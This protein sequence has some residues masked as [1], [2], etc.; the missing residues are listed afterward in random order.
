MNTKI[1]N[2]KLWNID[3]NGEPKKIEYSISQKF[4]ETI[5]TNFQYGEV[6]KTYEI[7]RGRYEI[8]NYISEKTDLKPGEININKQD[9]N[10]HP[11]QGA[12]FKIYGLK[13]NGGNNSPDNFEIEGTSDSSGSIKFTNI[14]PGV[15][16][17][18]ET[19]APEGYGQN[20]RT[21]TIT[22]RDDGSVEWT[23]NLISSAVSG[24]P[25][26]GTSWKS[27]VKYTNGSFSWP[28]YMNTLNYTEVDE[29]NNFTSY[30]M[31]KPDKNTLNDNG[32]KYSFTD[33]D[34]RIS[35]FG[36]SVNID[37]A[38]IFNV[39]PGQRQSVVDS[40]F[41][42]NAENLDLGNDLSG[43]KNTHD[44][45]IQR[46]KS[47][48]DN[49]LNKTV[50]FAFLIPFG[51]FGAPDPD[52]AY[53]FLIKVKGKVLSTNNADATISY[54][55]LTTSQPKKRPAHNYN[56]NIGDAEIGSQTKIENDTLIP[57]LNKRN[58]A[59]APTFTVVNTQ[60]K[61]TTLNIQ[62]LDDK[63]NQ[64][65]GAEF[66]LYNS[67]GQ[68]IRTGTTEVGGKLTFDKLAPGKY[69]LKETKSPSGYYNPELTFNV[70]VNPDGS[71]IYD[72][73]DKN[74]KQVEEGDLYKVGENKTGGTS[75][76]QGTKRITV[77]GEP[78]MYLNESNHY[79]KRPGVWEEA[80]YESY[81]FEAQFK[82]ENCKAGDSWV[83]DFD[84]NWNFTQ[85][86][87]EL[88]VLKVNDQEVARG[89]IDYRN[90][91]IKYTLTNPDYVDH[92][93]SIQVK[94]ELNS[95]R[96]SK[97]YVKN[98]GI[99][100]FR[101]I[102]NVGENQK[103]I[104]TEVNA[105]L[106]EFYGQDG[107][108]KYITENVDIYKDSSQNRYMMRNI[109]LFNVFGKKS[110]IGDTV[111][112]IYYGSSVN[113]GREILFGD[114]QEPAFEPTKVIVYEV[115]EAPNPDNM[116]LSC[117]IRP[118]ENPSLYKPL[119]TFDNIKGKDKGKVSDHGVTI[120]FDKSRVNINDNYHPQLYDT[121]QYQF[122]VKLPSLTQTDG[123]GY[124]IEQ[125]YEITDPTKFENTYTQTFMAHSAPNYTSMGI[126]QMRPTL[127][128]GT[129]IGGNVIIP[130]P[131]N[132]DLTV[133][134]K[135]QPGE[136]IVKKVSEEKDSNNN[137]IPLSGAEFILLDSNGRV[138][139]RN[140]SNKDGIVEFKGLSEGTYTL[141][142]TVPP[143]KHKATLRTV[144]VTVSAEGVVKFSEIKNDDKVFQVQTN[145]RNRKIKKTS[146]QL[147]EEQV[148]SHHGVYPAFMN[149]SSKVIEKDDNNVKTRIYLNPDTDPNN[150]NGPNK[151]TV[152]ELSA[153][154]TNQDITTVVYK[155]PR[156]FKENIDKYLSTNKIVP[157]TEEVKIISNKKIEF[158]SAGE[159]GRWNGAAYVIEVDAKYNEPNPDIGKSIVQDRYINYNWYCDPDFGTFMKGRVGTQLK[160]SNTE[161][162]PS[163][164]IVNGVVEINDSKKII[165]VVNKKDKTK[166]TIVKV[167]EENNKILPG[168]IFGIFG[169]DGKTALKKDNHNYE[170]E[171]DKN[172]K[173][174]FEDLEPGTYIIKEIKAPNGY[175]KTDKKWKVVVGNNNTVNV[176]EQNNIICDYK[177]S[178]AGQEIV[179][180]YGSNPL[181]SI[182][183]NIIQKNN[184]TLIGKLDIE[185]KQNTEDREFGFPLIFELDNQNFQY[186]FQG[187]YVD[188]ID[189]L[190]YPTSYIHGKN[191]FE[192]EIIPKKGT[193]LGEYKPITEIV[194]GKGRTK[195][196]LPTLTIT[197]KIEPQQGG[198]SGN[199]S[200]YKI[201]KS[202]DVCFI[203]NKVNGNQI[204]VA[205]IKS[206]I[207][208]IHDLDSDSYYINII[209]NRMYYTNLRGTTIVN[210]NTDLFDVS[211]VTKGI[212]VSKEGRSTFNID[213]YGNLGFYS[214]QY[215][216]TPKQGINTKILQPIKSMYCGEA[217]VYERNGNQIYLS[218][219]ENIGAPTPDPNPEPDPNPTPDPN[220]QPGPKPEPEPGPDPTP[221]PTV[222]DEEPIDVNQYGNEFVFT[223]K[224]KFKGFDVEFTKFGREETNG[225]VFLPGA[226][227]ELKI[228]DGDS[229]KNPIEGKPTTATSDKDG[230]VR[231]ENLKPGSYRI[232][233]TLT[234]DGYKK[235]EGAVKEFIIEKDGTV[236]V[237]TKDGFKT[238]DEDNGA[239]NI[240]NLKPGNGEF[241]IVKTDGK[242]TTK[243]KGVEFELYNSA[244]KVMNGELDRFST[245]KNG[246]IH[247]KGLSYDKY[248]VKEVK[249][250]PGYVLDSELRVVMIGQK[251]AKGTPTGTDVSDKLI[252]N[253]EES[254]MYSIIKNDYYITPNNSEVIQA[255]LKYTVDENAHI[256]P[257]DTFKVVASENV[258]LDGIGRS[259]DNEY[260]IYG[261][262]GL[263]A[264]AEIGK[265]RR[266]ITYTFTEY[267]KHYN[268]RSINIGMLMAVNRV[269]VSGDKEGKDTIYVSVTTG[270]SKVSQ[271]FDVKYN[272]GDDVQVNACLVKYI[273][274]SN[275]F[276]ANFYINHNNINTYG[277]M[278]KF[279]SNSE[280]AIQDVQVKYLNNDESFLPWSFG[281]RDNE[282]YLSNMKPE[283]YSVKKTNN[284]VILYLNGN[285]LDNR[286]YRVVVKGKVIKPNEDRFALYGEYTNYN[287]WNQKYYQK[288]G[289]YKSLKT[290][291]SSATGDIII[292]VPN[293]KNKIEYTKVDGTITGTAID[294]KPE[295]KTEDNNKQM[296]V[297]R[298]MFSSQ[299]NP[300]K[301]AKFVLKKDGSDKA[302]DG[303]E[304]TSDKYGKFS[305]EGLALG[306][307]EVWETE[308]PS[309]Y[310]KPK[311]P[312]SSFE[313]NDKGEIVV[314]SKD[315]I[316]IIKNYKKP[317]IEFK[318]VDGKKVEGQKAQVPLADAVFT[319]R[320]AKTNK[321]GK[322]V[323]NSDKLL[324][325]EDVK[326][327]VVV[328]GK[329]E[330]V[331]YTAISA[332]DGRFKFEKLED[333]IY[334][335]KETKA[336]KDYA[337][338]LDYALIFKV[339]GGKIYEVNKAGNYVDK[340][341][342]EVTDK[343]KANL[344]VD[345]E[346]G[347]AEV[348]T[349]QIENFKAEYPSTGG[350][351]ALPF[352]F[353]G[354]MIM[355]VGAYMFIRR[356]DALYE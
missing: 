18:Q 51:R 190:K 54:R 124:V 154:N 119:A 160:V 352:V 140:S 161:V 37:E 53:G 256:Q 66:S 99:Y 131:K 239:F 257:G 10:G 45:A 98:N 317:N 41:G 294:K 118:S 208:E 125:F 167:D 306:K 93:D 64:L 241:K 128:K 279:T 70:F 198:G 20:T 295:D 202:N 42:K 148:L 305:W 150:G 181:L 4:D 240:V 189:W 266:E 17:L 303:S 158:T 356:R 259:H 301:D 40:M 97:Y 109:A 213:F 248:Y 16:T 49:Y 92:H 175:E 185:S 114:K 43:I 122:F 135:K 60:A 85:W 72:A 143:D 104:D 297:P 287:T 215:K 151:K 313:V 281:I 196:K 144:T 80:A 3:A 249:T 6:Y 253:S 247:F 61:R 334:A 319:L 289:L 218:Y 193:K 291:D 292:N 89:V 107:N 210:F 168:A 32:T 212:S 12:T 270:T 191:T 225:D 88:P 75:G 228:K 36:E 342:K 230:K 323:K 8:Q 57:A 130:Q 221:G 145:G 262:A 338:L 278:M 207:G 254:K 304:R 244:G 174:T 316:T 223:V 29:K 349:I 277:K 87:G 120:D 38:Q 169:S 271:K 138:I 245:D 206:D 211:P 347:K 179:I 94:L 39:A 91:Q 95:I 309:E 84:D 282:P 81:S 274:G 44:G 263:L 311:N 134:N 33:R 56:Q 21:D 14:P 195:D 264:T 258:D 35:I 318:K 184:G 71:I 255:N 137:N 302:L 58:A 22:V 280:V 296:S 113:N 235:P 345:I 19:K 335:V 180:Q 200:K 2:V 147:N 83:M 232:F 24:N 219:L 243:L 233:E 353:I 344:L 246:E 324:E 34:T 162:D 229:Y 227:F 47:F 217:P 288:I 186:K 9:E 139:R 336:P 172:G 205:E 250:L 96:P 31:L 275:D 199:F 173:A 52:N 261:P 7:A 117:G 276:V 142:E 141:K 116:P 103:R 328:N 293:Y 187:R 251:W 354:M 163:T 76:L 28:G 166:V 341:K 79:G 321:D 121:Q 320:K 268:I 290:P 102:I 149:I 327:E 299:E 234:P 237:N 286:T 192:F 73:I 222:T 308:T 101:D 170:V 63:N 152:L 201:I 269:E 165:Q 153:F 265:N 27:D 155:V 30:I 197:R 177:V 220:P 67:F 312:V 13:N 132:Y 68:I 77:I 307:Y 340:N 194:I 69:T 136:F 48:R 74:G 332:A 272:Y 224:N 106:K 348:K 333:G 26:N 78:R 188:K 11:L 157:S 236:K 90:N 267:A 337:M 112:R 343:T 183:T 82:L 325:F 178:N 171:T 273:E 5:G 226:V 204:D 252:L 310:S 351:G 238:F 55:W 182:T 159:P 298:P 346:T 330:T 146:E 105:D 50:P 350:V 15:Y 209:I 285:Y 126:A 322:F 46:K 164:P 214:V 110:F 127:N 339:E 59:F 25:N 355:M 260:D 115:L 129:A 329:N 108:V 283:D 284:G 133:Y 203:W 176:F 331:P 314:T 100:K 123:K 242:G 62:K 65:S 86:S 156:E 315:N 23:K 231:F 216:L 111:A 1:P 300:L 326:R